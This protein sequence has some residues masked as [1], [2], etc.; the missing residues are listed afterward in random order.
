MNRNRNLDE[1]LPL[2]DEVGVNLAYDKGEI[3]LSATNFLLVVLHIQEREKPTISKRTHEEI[4]L[5]A[6]RLVNALEVDIKQVFEFTLKKIQPKTLI[7]QGMIEQIKTAIH[8]QQAE[9]VVFDTKLSPTQQR[10][11]EKALQAKVLDRTGLILEIFGAR[12]RTKEGTLQVELAHLIYQ[13]SR[14]VRSWTHLERQRGGL[15]FI[16]GPGESQL[17][18]DRRQLQNRILQLQNHLVKVRKTRAL[19]RKAR[20][21]IPYPIIALV[22]YTNAGKSTLFNALSTA[23]VFAKDMLFATLDPTARRVS[24]PSGKEV[25]LSDTVGFIS[26]LPTEL[27]EAFRATLE[28]V[29]SADVILHVRDMSSSARDIERLDVIKTLEALEIDYENDERI[30]EVWNKID[31]LSEEDIAYLTNRQEKQREAQSFNAHLPSSQIV[32][33]SP[34]MVSSLDGTGFDN[35]EQAI[36]NIVGKNDVILYIQLHPSDGEGYSWLHQHGEILQ[37]EMNEDYSRDLQV[38]LSKK[39]YGRAAKKFSFARM[40]SE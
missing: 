31:L 21:D 11:L 29:L 32:D 23:E 9:V 16:G 5:E 7:G 10:N 18:S 22:G 30:I 33:R 37:E 40:Y 14:L 20:A 28:E 27:I 39:D 8:D 6:E 26:N 4:R 34:V 25:I 19:H 13:K 2:S 1:N 38:R 12:A 15:G 3:A 36:D 17:E 24:L 35:L